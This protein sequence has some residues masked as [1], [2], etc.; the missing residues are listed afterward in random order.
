[1][2]ITLCLKLKQKRRGRANAE[3]YL[4]DYRETGG[5]QRNRPTKPPARE[6]TIPP[7]TAA[8]PAEQPSTI[9]ADVNPQDFQPPNE[10]V[11]EHLRHMSHAEAAHI[12]DLVAM[13]GGGANL[14]EP[15]PERND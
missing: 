9:P 6:R 14:D 4:R 8:P 12:R 13:E 3:G 7:A 10:V 11:S 2:G 5:I 15:H 1:M